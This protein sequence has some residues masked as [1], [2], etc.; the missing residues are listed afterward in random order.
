[1]FDIIRKDPDFGRLLN[2]SR[3]MGRF[4][5]GEAYAGNTGAWL[6]PVDIWETEKAMHV[7]CEV[8]GLQKDDI[9]LSIANNVLTLYG[10]K[11]AE[12]D[13]SY[14]WHRVERQYGKFTRSFTLPRDV[15]A[16]KIEAHYEAGLLKLTLPKLAE[17]IPHKIAI[18]G[19]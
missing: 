19:K 18:T 4:F 3:E 16:S 5:N 2:L 14:N 7:V 9:E 13:K 15:D 11:K 10:E 12:D 17:A 8:P 1:M 6:P